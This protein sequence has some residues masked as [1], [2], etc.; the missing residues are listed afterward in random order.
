MAEIEER[1]RRELD[2]VLDRIRRAGGGVVFEE[3]PGMFEDSSAADSIDDDKQSTIRGAL[4]DE[5]NALAEAREQFR[6]WRD[7][8]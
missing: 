7:G 2:A 5:A 3:F 1:L 8:A 4:I 6:R